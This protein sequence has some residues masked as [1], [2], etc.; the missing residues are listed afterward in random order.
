ME[1]QAS[2]AFVDPEGKLQISSSTQNPHYLH[3]QLARVL[4]LREWQIR[5]VA[6]PN[7]GGFG[8]KCDP[9]GHEFVVAKAALVLGRPV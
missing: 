7:G 5:V 4:G 2:V 8:G 9:G 6:T 1:Q 3:R